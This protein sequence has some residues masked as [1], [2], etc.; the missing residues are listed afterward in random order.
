MSPLRSYNGRFRR[1]RRVRRR[2]RLRKAAALMGAT[3]AQQGGPL[4][5]GTASPAPPAPL[6]FPK[7][8][9]APKEADRSRIKAMGKDALRQ[10]LDELGVEYDARH[11]AAKLKA[12]LLQAVTSAKPPSKADDNGAS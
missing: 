2:K 1:R 3:S 6:G 7:P 10:E 12:T 8:V 9:G 11:G 4:A 5:A